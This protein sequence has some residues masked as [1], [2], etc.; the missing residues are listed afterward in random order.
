MDWYL[1]VCYAAQSA[2]TKCKAGVLSVS[3]CAASIARLKRGLSGYS[4]VTKPRKSQDRPRRKANGVVVQQMVWSNLA[5]LW[6]DQFGGTKL[7]ITFIHKDV[8]VYVY[9]YIYKHRYLI[10][11]IYLIF[12]LYISIGIELH[13]YTYAAYGFWTHIFCFDFRDVRYDTIWLMYDRLAVYKYLPVCIGCLFMFICTRTV[14]YIR[15]K[16]YTCW[17]KTMFYI[18][19][20]CK[21]ITHTYIHAYIQVYARAHA[22]M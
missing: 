21:Y 17:M 16:V 10:T 8:Y 19:L 20:E 4:R 9:V 1:I 11:H 14:H 18:L 15:S 22:Y 5:K 13:T 6:M 12:S 7:T 2:N 3:S